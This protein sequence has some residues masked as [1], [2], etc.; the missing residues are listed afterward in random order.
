MYKILLEYICQNDINNR[1]Y[2]LNGISNIPYVTKFFDNN[3]YMN[4]FIEPIREIILQF[5]IIHNGKQFKLIKNLFIPKL[6][7]Y[8]YRKNQE[9]AY[10]LISTFCAKKVPTLEQSLIFEKILWDSKDIKYLDIED[11]CKRLEYFKNIETISQKIKNV[12]ELLDNFLLFVKI[13]HYNFLKKYNIIPNINSELIKLNEELAT[14]KDVPDNMKELLMKL[15]SNWTINH[16]NENILKYSTGIYHNIDDS[17]NKIRRSV[18]TLEDILLI[19]QYIPNDKDEKYI[20]KRKTIFDLCKYIW[21]EY[22]F[23][24]K[25]GNEFPEELWNKFDD[26]IIKEIIKIKE[27]EKK[28]TENEGFDFM[29]KLLIF[30]E[31]YYPKEINEYAIIPNQNGKLF[32]YS[33]LYKDSDI[34]EIFK[35]SVKD[36]IN[37]DIKDELLD[38]NFNEIFEM[39]EKKIYDY[40]SILCLFFKKYDYNQIMKYKKEELA[41]KLLSIIPKMDENDKKNYYDFQTKQVLLYNLYKIFTKN[42]LKPYIIEK[43]DLNY[44]I[45][46]YS[47]KYIY[48]IIQAHI[49]Q[50]KN[51]FSFENIL[52]KI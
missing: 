26:Y 9:K 47:N 10:D 2:L 50:N 49:E 19:M 3:W 11:C 8:S 7:C 45:W 42:K 16:I 32:K 25:N 21:K 24:E 20:E 46:Q 27:K 30:L 36:Y 37:I 43:N 22:I 1:H 40:S 44:K 6:N 15:D 52:V 5:P 39:K 38:K 35:V 29:K 12:W 41:I 28:I 48:D 18:K 31:E 51:L 14:F 17:V 13:N 23:E 4:N 33:E 34:P